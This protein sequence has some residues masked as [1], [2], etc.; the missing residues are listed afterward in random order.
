VEHSST[1]LPR[2]S[3]YVA[4][5]TVGSSRFTG[6]H[7]CPACGTYT[8]PLAIAV[9]AG[10][11]GADA[12]GLTIPIPNAEQVGRWLK[13]PEVPSNIRMRRHDVWGSTFS[14]AVALVVIFLSGLMAFAILGYLTIPVTIGTMVFY[15]RKSR[16]PQ[17]H[18][19]SIAHDQ[20][21]ILALRAWDR[22]MEI[23]ERLGVCPNCGLMSDPITER[24][25]E[26]HSVPSLFV[27]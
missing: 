7:V 16:A 5:P 1:Q 6:S 22:R 13:P 25:A 23:W 3:R 27:G 9:R 4:T 8:L 20:H 14:L 21:R 17:E 18:K 15:Y 12:A 19:G 11:G 26:W 10:Q 24:T 2:A